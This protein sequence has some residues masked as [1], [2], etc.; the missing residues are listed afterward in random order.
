[1]IF[2]ICGMVEF[3]SEDGVMWNLE[4]PDRRSSFTTIPARLFTYLLEN[5]DKIISREELLDNIWEKYGL[6]PSNNSVNQYISMIRKSLI[7]LGCEEEIIQTIPRVGFFIAKE[8]V[9]RNE[10]KGQNA[11]SVVSAQKPHP[12]GWQNILRQYYKQTLIIVSLTVSSLLVIQPF[13]MIG[14]LD[15]TFPKSTLYK[16]GSINTCPVYSLTQ[17][18]LVVAEKKLEFARELASANID[19]IKNAVFIF[20]PGVNYIYTKTGRAF[21]TR[22]IQNNGSLSY[23]SDC[24]GVYVYNK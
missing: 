19:C 20:Q 2:T 23:F 13:G 11:E 5:A 12:E 14:G 16:L 10:E 22:C 15:Y 6:E 4:H 1:M 8:M 18:S 21:L 17:N 7:E 9:S 24:K 3:R